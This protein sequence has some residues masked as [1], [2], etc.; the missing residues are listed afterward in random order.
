M[1]TDEPTS[2]P[3]RRASAA[4]IAADDDVELLD[5]G[6]GRR[7]ERF[8]PVLLDRPAPVVEG[9]PRRD[10]SAWAAADARY[11]RGTG[12]TGPRPPSGP[13]RVR[14]GGVGLTCRLSAEGGVGCY[15]E[16]AALWRLLA[17]E[18]AATPGARVLN[19]FGHTG[20]LTI[21]AAGAG[22]AVAHVDAS[23]AAVAT[24]RANAEADGLGRAPV[25]WIVDD[26][27]AFVEREGR[28]GRRYDLVVL[29]PPSYGHGRSGR[30]WR[31]D[32]DLP[33]LV[34]AAGR[35][36]AGPGSSLVVT[37]HSTGWTED[38][39]RWLVED[40]MGTG[41]APGG[42]ASVATW[43]TALT[44]RSGAILPAGIGARWRAAT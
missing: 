31:L 33:R 16:H 7:L 43:S 23:R 1:V 36:L 17:A 13:W 21:A 30:A 41:A 35:L 11:D 3:G 42:D 28:R 26:A 10:P 12:W 24:A 20:G 32:V 37:L 14:L 15:P 18:L 40:A 39:L 19:A 2:I 22:A 5:S 6:D 25:R 44:A 8:G 29:D 27:S 34:A 4:A 38:R 9:I